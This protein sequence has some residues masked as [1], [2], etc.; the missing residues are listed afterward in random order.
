LRRFSGFLDPC[1]PWRGVGQ[2]RRLVVGGWWLVVAGMARSYG[3]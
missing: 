2:L 1:D 3:L